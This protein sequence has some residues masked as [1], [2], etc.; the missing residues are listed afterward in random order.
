MV[1]AQERGLRYHR[2]CAAARRQLGNEAVGRLY[3]A[4]GE[5]YWYTPAAGELMERLA[6]SRDQRRPRR[7]RAVARVYRKPSWMQPTTTPGMR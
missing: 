6:A 7:D 1:E 4:W 2:I 5:S 3:R